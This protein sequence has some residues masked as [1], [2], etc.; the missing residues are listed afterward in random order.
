M[1]ATTK[2]DHTNEVT[3]AS[4]NRPAS[5]PSSEG[6]PQAGS[7]FDFKSPVQGSHPNP[8]QTQQPNQQAAAVSAPQQGGEPVWTCGP[9]TGERELHQGE[10]HEDQEKQARC[11]RALL[12]RAMLGPPLPEGDGH[13]CSSGMAAAGWQ[14]GMVA[15]FAFIVAALLMMA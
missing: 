3:G 11:G 9:L 1:Q 2:G 13:I 12:E 8:P 6:P 7:P 15:N 14:E 4:P 5:Q 10:P